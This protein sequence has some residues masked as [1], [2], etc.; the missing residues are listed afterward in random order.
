MRITIFIIIFFFL[1]IKN[2]YAL[3]IT[4]EEI[5]DNPSD[6]ELNLNYAKQ[7][8][9][10]GN[11]KLTIATLE[12]LSMLYPENLDIKLYLLSILIEMD[13]A[14]KVELMVRT[15][16]NDPNTSDK[17]K[18]IIADL[19]VK[20]KEEVKKENKWFAYLDLTY[21]QTKENNIS[22]VTKNKKIMQGNT[23]Q[24]YP[25]VDRSIVVKADRTRKRAASITLGKN[26]DDSSSFFINLGAD[27]NDVDKK[28]KGDNDILSTSLSYFKMFGNH[29]VSPYLYWTRPNYT[30]QEDYQSIGA[31]I[32]N[33]LILNE[34]NNINYSLAFSDT[35]Y[36]SNSKFPSANESNSNVYS[37]FVRHNYN[38]SN[39]KQLGSRLILNRTETLKE[40][41]TYYSKGISLSYSQIYPI[42][43]FNLTGTYLENDYEERESFISNKILRSD[44]SLVTSLSLSGQINQILPFIRTINSDNSIFYSLNLKNSDVSSNIVN[45]D[46]ERNFFTISLTKRLNI[47]VTK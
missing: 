4:Y 43:T 21:A 20:T 40:Y 39:N 45:Y 32:N 41:D 3:N 12:R 37:S 44:E 36:N 30:G 35:V 29:Y 7:Q 31:G 47:D 14:V 18:K 17:T 13:S 24:T 19:L 2:V 23:L 6:L 8:E 11:L 26:I 25:L 10:Q 1:L 27:I 33:T 22:G 5:L 9:K 46:V 28:V 34:K 16:M 42:G 38:F 15:M